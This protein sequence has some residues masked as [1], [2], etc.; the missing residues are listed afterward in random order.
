MNVN[1]NKFGE[2]LGRDVDSGFMLIN[3]NSSTNIS[4]NPDYRKCK[5]RTDLYGK[6]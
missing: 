4:Y 3:R 5:P 1:V 2:Q 6:M